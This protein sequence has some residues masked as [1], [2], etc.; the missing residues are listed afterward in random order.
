[1]AADDTAE[2]PPTPPSFVTLPSHLQTTA[3]TRCW[4]VRSTS[5]SSST[6]SP[7]SGAIALSYV[8]HGFS[9]DPAVEEFLLHPPLAADIQK[10][11]FI[12]TLNPLPGEHSDKGDNRL[13]VLI[14]LG[15]QPN[16]EV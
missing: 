6:I 8:P 16:H 4:T 13:D 3:L 9:F 2:A 14:G 11:K 1:M 12:A 10:R 15:R 5:G 7:P